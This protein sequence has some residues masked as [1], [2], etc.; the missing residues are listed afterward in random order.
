MRLSVR[1][2]DVFRNWLLEDPGT[3]VPL[4]LTALGALLV[5]PLAGFAVYLWRLAAR[6]VE[7]R[8]F[9]PNGYRVVRQRPAITGD[10]AIGHARGIRAVAIFLVV[11]AA[12]LVIVLWRL[13]VLI[14]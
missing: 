2:M 4:T 9:P 1:R 13:A 7:G 5:L 11:A 14:T 3:R 6:V 8:E 12:A 10:A